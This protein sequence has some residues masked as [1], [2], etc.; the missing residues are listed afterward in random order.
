VQNRIFAATATE[1]SIWHNFASFAGSGCMLQLLCTSPPQL[2]FSSRATAFGLFWGID[3]QLW[4]FIYR[5]YSFQNG[6]GE[7]F[8]RTVLQ[9]PSFRAIFLEKRFR[10]Q[11]CG[12]TLGTAFASFPDQFRGSSGNHQWN[13][14]QH[15]WDA[16]FGELWR[17]AVGIICGAAWRQTLT[18]KFLRIKELGSAFGN[19]FYEGTQACSWSVNLKARLVTSFG[20]TF[21][22]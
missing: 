18:T 10:E 4:V 21:S 14:R 19:K 17:G 3:L 13:F 22:E 2:R 8:C 6:F 15:F 7:F 11:F 16:D 20:S 1:S 9:N 5:Q 12:A